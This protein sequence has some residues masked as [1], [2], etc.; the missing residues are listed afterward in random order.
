ML[1]EKADISP[2]RLSLFTLLLLYPL[3]PF[4]TVTVYRI[5]WH[6]SPPL[7]G[8]CETNALSW[9]APPFLTYLPLY[10]LYR[11]TATTT[12]ADD[13]YIT[14]DKRTRKAYR[15]RRTSSQ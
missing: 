11:H 1:N 2:H 5:I 3:R 10:T 7:C 14:A 9:A 4:Q 13:L 6:I 8:P 15:P 12:M